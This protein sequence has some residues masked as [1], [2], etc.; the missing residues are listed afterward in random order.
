MQS[1][2]LKKMGRLKEHFYTSPLALHWKF[3]AMEQLLTGG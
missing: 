3:Y 1:D 2:L